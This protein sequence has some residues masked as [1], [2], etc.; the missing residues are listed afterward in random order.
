MKFSALSIFL[1][2]SSIHRN[3]PKPF[4]V[5][6]FKELVTEECEDWIYKDWEIENQV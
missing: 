5:I 6:L 2:S 3:L 1:S 4:W